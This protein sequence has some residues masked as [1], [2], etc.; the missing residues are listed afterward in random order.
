MFVQSRGLS[1][2]WLWYYSLLLEDY[3]LTIVSSCEPVYALNWWVLNLFP[4]YVFSSPICG[5]QWWCFCNF[6]IIAGV[7][8]LR[9]YTVPS[10]QKICPSPS[11]PRLGRDAMTWWIRVTQDWRPQKGGNS[12]CWWFR[13]PA[14]KPIEVGSLSHYLQGFMYTSQVVNAGFQPSTVLVP[15][16]GPCWCPWPSPGFQ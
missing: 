5:N 7:G 3:I 6:W 9:I 15:L 16:K 10:C 1:G 12:Y 4:S 8:C 13:N 14:R 2:S 11:V